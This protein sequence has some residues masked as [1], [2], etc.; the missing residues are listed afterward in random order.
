MPDGLAQFSQP[1]VTVSV[2]QRF[3]EY[4]A[5]EE[6][7]NLLGADTQRYGSAAYKKK[8]AANDHGSG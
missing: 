4:A 1:L 2:N 6:T 3:V 7:V 8:A 5:N